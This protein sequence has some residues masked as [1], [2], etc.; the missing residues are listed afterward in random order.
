[1]ANWYGGHKLGSGK[2]AGTLTHDKAPVGRIVCTNETQSFGEGLC[3]VKK[4][5]WLLCTVKVMSVAT[6][7]LIRKERVNQQT[8]R[9]RLF[10]T[11]SL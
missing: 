1:M 7:S 2:C 8:F 10:G 3:F 6:S 4:M 5:G 9:H 11:E